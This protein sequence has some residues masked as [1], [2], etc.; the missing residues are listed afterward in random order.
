MLDDAALL[1]PQ[2]SAIHNGAG[3]SRRRWFVV[4]GRAAHHPER[5]GRFPI[6][7]LPYALVH[8]MIAMSHHGSDE[9]SLAYLPLFLYCRGR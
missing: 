8:Q 9:L 3:P 6:A 1:P 2:T 5:V 4:Y 7:L